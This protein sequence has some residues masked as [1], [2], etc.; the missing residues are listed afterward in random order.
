M[1]KH[2]IG[3]MCSHDYEEYIKG[4]DIDILRE[5]L[6]NEMERIKKS[7]KKSLFRSILDWF[8]K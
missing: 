3:K 2:Y 4:L 6:A 5:N 7:K 8:K 1:N